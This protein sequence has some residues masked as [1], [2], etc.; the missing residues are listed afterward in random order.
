MILVNIILI[1]RI[2]LV[3]Q[4]KSMSKIKNISPTKYKKSHFTECDG[5]D[6]LSVFLRKGRKLFPNFSS[7]EKRAIYDGDLDYLDNEMKIKKIFRC[8]IKALKHIY[9]TY[10]IEYK[11][12]FACSNKVSFD[13]LFFFLVDIGEQ[14]FYY[15]NLTSFHPL[16]VERCVK[17]K[18]SLLVNISD[19]TL[20]SSAEDLVT[21]IENNYLYSVSLSDL[22]MEELRILM[23]GITYLNNSINN[24]PIIRD[25]LFKNFYS[26]VVEYQKDTD[27]GAKV[28]L[29]SNK[30]NI[31]TIMPALIDEKTNLISKCCKRDLVPGRFVC[32]S[33]GGSAINEQNFKNYLGLLINEFFTY[34]QYLL[35]IMP[36]DIICEL[37]FAAINFEYLKLNNKGFEK[38]F[39]SEEISVGVLR[40]FVFSKENPYAVYTP[41]LVEE[42]NKRDIAVI[43]KIWHYWRNS[44]SLFEISDS[45]EILINETKLFL[46]KYSLYCD[47]VASNLVDAKLNLQMSFAYTLTNYENT[48]TFNANFYNKS[49]FDYFDD[50]TEMRFESTLHKGGLFENMKSFSPLFGSIINRCYQIV[51]YKLDCEYKPIILDGINYFLI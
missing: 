38:W 40:D 6:M 13:P 50:D 24:V 29:Y 45:K 16:E 28:G 18:E 27:E 26:F 44:S 17:N 21:E 25:V 48:K 10:R 15:L 2:D 39:N 31:L 46:N 20:L 51:S 33:F 30:H 12:L 8:Q 22:N 4:I 14:K 42:C 41:F 3:N 36:S 11:Y 32:R 37:F 7:N 34:N 1:V 19:F 5:V 35:S 47:Y 43:K 23:S 49:R 9:R